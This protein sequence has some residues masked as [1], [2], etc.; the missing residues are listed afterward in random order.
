MKTEE[1]AARLVDTF[2][3]AEAEDAQRHLAFLQFSRA[4]ER[5]DKLAERQAIEREYIAGGCLF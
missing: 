5:A 2:R 4:S 3:R 1:I